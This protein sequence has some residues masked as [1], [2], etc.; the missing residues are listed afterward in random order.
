MW[1]WRWTE[2]SWTDVRNEGVLHRVKE[3]RSLLNKIKRR[4]A[5][6]IGHVL[7]RNCLLRDIIEG[8]REGG[9]EVTGRHGRRGKQLLLDE[10][11]KTLQ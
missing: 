5:S 11:K 2:I 1:C 8:K 3:E 6:L 10:L 4:W 7:L 9:I